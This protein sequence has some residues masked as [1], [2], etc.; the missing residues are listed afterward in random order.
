[1]LSTIGGWLSTAVIRFYPA[2]E[3]TNQLEEFTGAVIRWLLL[4]VITL[5]ALFLG[6][7][8][9]IKISLGNQLYHLMMVGILVFIL[10]TVFAVLQQFLRAK[11]Q[12]GRY[13]GIF[14][15]QS[16]ASISI[17]IVLVIFLGFGIEGLLWGS[18]LSLAVVLPLLWKLTVQRQP[19]RLG[20]NIGLAKEMAKYAIPLMLANLAAWILSL[21]DRYILGYF[22]SSQQVGIYSVSYG[23]SEKSI[24]LLTSLFMLTARPLE[25]SVWEK[26]G[27]AK[28]RQFVTS[29]TRYYLM[30]CL[31]AIVGLSVLARPVIDV[32]APPEY[33]QGYR[34]VP[35]VAFG[36]FLLG[37]QQ[38][39]QAGLAFY[40]KTNLVMIA[41]ITAGLL[42]LGLNVLLIPRYSYMAAATTTLIGY[43]I[44]L[45]MMIIGSRKYFVWRFPFKSFGKIALSSGVMSAVVYPIGNSLTSST[46]ASLFT[47]IGV[48][49]IVYVLMLL[50]L[51]ELRKDEIKAV[52]EFGRK[53]LGGKVS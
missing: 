47:A 25:A 35:L 26:E 37:L 38:R 36:I 23:I 29:I 39:F 31:P 3:K 8:S 12:I 24:L 46:L 14:V 41:I 5:A 10:T 52:K 50:L 34:V 6:I 49:V 9:L 27:E 16:I 22:H 40:K 48:G 11:R 44:L 53:I 19:W 21:S 1:M 20:F 51:R 33:Y 18:A 42:N 45:S 4:S 43:A 28:S 7:T 17:G 15:W 13:S 32:I 2:Y 30:V